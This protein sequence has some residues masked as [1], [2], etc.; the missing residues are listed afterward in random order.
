MSRRVNILGLFFDCAEKIFLFRSSG[1]D[2]FDFCRREM[3]IR[4]KQSS[5]KQE[6]A[7]KGR[8]RL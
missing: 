5:A 8:A 7:E 4:W 1:F 3:F 6:A 2:F